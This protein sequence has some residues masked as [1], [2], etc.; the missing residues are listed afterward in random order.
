MCPRAPLRKISSDLKTRLIDE[1]C[2]VQIPV[3]NCFNMHRRKFLEDNKIKFENF[4]AGE[5]HLFMM[6]VLCKAKNMIKIDKPF[7]VYRQRVGSL[8]KPTSANF[9]TFPKR[10]NDIFSIPSI[11]E[12]ILSTAMNEKN[13]PI[14]EPLIYLVA[15]KCIEFIMEVNILP[16]YQSDPVK[17]L[18]LI[19]DEL[20]T[21][22]NDES[23][24]IT[25]ILYGFVL[26]NLQSK[27]FMQENFQLKNKINQMINNPFSMMSR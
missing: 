9:K 24:M 13:I 8:S 11:C 14:D 15:T 4:I 12:K 17:T 1:Y 18:T 23:K 20:K 25:T 6:N 5:D 3:T 26:K 19:N 22:F 27:F 21:K 16:F 7:Y 10:I 2:N